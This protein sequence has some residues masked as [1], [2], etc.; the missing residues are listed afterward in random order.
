M[1]GLAKNL[2]QSND[3]HDVTRDEMAQNQPRS[4]RGKLIDI[5]DQYETAVPWQRTQEPVHQIHIHHRAFIHHQQVARQ[6]VALIPAKPA[7]AELDF[8]QPVNGLGFESGS[9]REPFRRSTCRGAEKQ[10]IF[11]LR[12]IC[13][14]ALSKVV[15]PT[16]GPPVMIK[17]RLRSAC[18]TA[19][20]W[21]G[22]TLCL[23]LAPTRQ[24]PSPHRTRVAPPRR[25]TT[26]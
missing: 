20:C 7:V 22:P 6:W 17:T 15:L 10:L 25:R 23:L 24:S 8:Q 2:G 12:R 3:R 4:N 18:R 13:K 5:A 16:P 14:S 26:L 9:L 19:S 1:S 21:A 11:L